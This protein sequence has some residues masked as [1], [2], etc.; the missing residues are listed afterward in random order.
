MTQATGLLTSV[1]SIASTL[2]SMA[3][4]RLALLANEIEEDRLHMIRLLFLGLLIMFFF[5]LGIVLLTLLIIAIFWD[6][7]RLLVI[8]LVA[9][10]YLGIA[11]CLAAYAVFNA[12][13]KPRL[14]AISL[15][16]LAKDRAIL[17]RGK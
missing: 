6:T 2:I 17:E 1:K 13:H 9:T 8:G 11:A 14:F 10:V 7:N 12:K 4:T 3:Q 15:A 5:C 16:E